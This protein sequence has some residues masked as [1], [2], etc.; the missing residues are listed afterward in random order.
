MSMQKLFRFAFIIFFLF[1]GAY[2]FVNPSFYLGMIPDYIPEAK[3]VNTLTGLTEL[4]IG[5]L[6]IFG[7]TRKIAA[8]L[9]IALLTAFI[10]AHLYFIQIGSCIPDGLCVPEWLSYLRLLVVHPLLYTWAWY[11]KYEGKD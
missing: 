11:I 2:H 3:L 9:A 8:Y 7:S 6:A 4:L 1:A 5:V 10:P